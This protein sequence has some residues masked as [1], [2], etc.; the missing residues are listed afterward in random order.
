VVKGTQFVLYIYVYN[1][2]PLLFLLWVLVF[3]C[4]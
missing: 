1:V 2:F 4:S 3:T